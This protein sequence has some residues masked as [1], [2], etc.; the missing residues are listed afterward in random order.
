MNESISKQQ[1]DMPWM[2]IVG[3]LR[4]VWW[5]GQHAGNTMLKAE[6]NRALIKAFRIG[7]QKAQEEFCE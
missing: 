7:Y 3:Y 2:E 5:V 6:H 4:E 1:E